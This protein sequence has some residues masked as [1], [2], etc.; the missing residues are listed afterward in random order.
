[1]SG[2]KVFSEVKI[3][4]WGKNEARETNV[5]EEVWEGERRVRKVVGEGLGVV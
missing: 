1:M 3:S 2:L 5:L 4:I